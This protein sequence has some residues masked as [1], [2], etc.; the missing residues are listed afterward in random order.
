MVNESLE[1]GWKT[2]STQSNELQLLQVDMDNRTTQGSGFFKM[3]EEAIAAVQE[4]L[5]H[6]LYELAV[7]GI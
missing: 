5:P 2:W 4:D 1:K 7:E 6:D 3:S